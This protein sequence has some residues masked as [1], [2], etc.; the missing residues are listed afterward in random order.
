A[1]VM[2]QGAAGER[3]ASN[4]EGLVALDFAIGETAGGVEQPS[5]T[6]Q[7]ADPSAERAEPRRLF[8]VHK[9]TGGRAWKD[10]NNAAEAGDAGIA[11]RCATLAA[12]LDVSL[13][14][15]QPVVGLPVVA[16][17]TTA[18]YAV[19]T[20]RRRG[21]YRPG[22]AKRGCVTAPAEAAAEVQAGIPTG[23]AVNRRRRW[24]RLER[25]VGR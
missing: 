22:R 17:L 25:Q 9:G 2:G 12:A 8:L 4:G 15:D 13:E 20:G 19:E 7:D 10:G 11:R 24:R 16:D 14:S 18:D 3:A 23:P 6:C 5:G 1:E 21:Q